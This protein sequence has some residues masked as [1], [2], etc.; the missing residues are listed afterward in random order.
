VRNVVELQPYRERRVVRRCAAIAL[1]LLAVH[2]L[3]RSLEAIEWAIRKAANLLPPEDTDEP[4]AEPA[5]ASR[6]A[7]DIY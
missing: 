7:A 5:L 1:V 2:D 3:A 6:R 4:A